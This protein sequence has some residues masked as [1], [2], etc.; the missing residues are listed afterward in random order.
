MVAALFTGPEQSLFKWVTR[1]RLVKGNV[2][3]EPFT[4]LS[5]SEHLLKL[6]GKEDREG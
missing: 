5:N 3:G 6:T 2:Q 4:Q 1:P